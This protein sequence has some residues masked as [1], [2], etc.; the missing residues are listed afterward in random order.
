MKKTET[1]YS[2]TLDDK[3]IKVIVE[4]TNRRS[5]GMKALPD[6]QFEIKLPLNCPNINIQEFLSHHKRW[7]F[8]RVKEYEERQILPKNSKMLLGKAYPCSIIKNKISNTVKFDGQKFVIFCSDNANI[9]VMMDHFYHL[10]AKNIF[11]KIL[12]EVAKQFEPL[13]VSYNKL[14]VKK[15]S[16]RWGSCT[17][18]GNINLNTNLIKMP[19]ECIRVVATHEMCHRVYMNHSKEFYDLLTKMMPDWKIWSKKLKICFL[20]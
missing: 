18:K 5:L 20:K 8:Q 16:T 2:I 15:M 4:K 6:G 14:S 19:E 13:N 7:I 10:K 9:D 3:T 1:T 11:P 12:D 17:S